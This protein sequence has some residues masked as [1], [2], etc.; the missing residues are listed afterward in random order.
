MTFIVHCHPYNRD[1][2]FSLGGKFAPVKRKLKELRMT[3]Q[4]IE[5]FRKDFEGYHVGPNK[6]KT[7]Q[8]ST[9]QQIVQVPVPMNAAQI[10]LLGHEVLHA[11]SFVLRK[12]GIEH[13]DETEEAYTYLHQF[14]MH[15][16]LREVGEK[17]WK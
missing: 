5:K 14:V 13:T 3:K 12:A 16:V 9:G 11:V 1:I 10:A 15:Q 8:L 17:H 7:W 2:L 4:D 6:G